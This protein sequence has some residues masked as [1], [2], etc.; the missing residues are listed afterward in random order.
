MRLQRYPWFQKYIDT[1]GH[2]KPTKGKN[3]T[4]G[5][6]MC[7]E[8]VRRARRH[9]FDMT[10]EIMAAMG[11]FEPELSAI[12]GDDHSDSFEI[13]ILGGAWT[14]ECVAASEDGV[15]ATQDKL[16]RDFRGNDQE[17]RFQS[18]QTTRT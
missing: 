4:L 7:H 16:K 1:A 18:D 10:D 15:D 9:L 17:V 12:L 6:P 2:A 11:C 5:S 8:A 14:A 3:A 13:V